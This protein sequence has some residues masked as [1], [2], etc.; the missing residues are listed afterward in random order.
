MYRDIFIA[1]S[2]THGRPAPVVAAMLYAF[3]PVAAYWYVRNVQAEVPFDVTWKAFED[4][5]TGKTLLDFLGEYGLLDLLPAIKEYRTRVEDYR[6]KYIRFSGNTA[7][8]LNQFFVAVRD[9]DKRE[10]GVQKGLD[11]VGGSW[12]SLMAYVRVWTFLMKDWKLQMKLKPREDQ[13]EPVF[14]KFMVSLSA[15]KV[16]SKLSV[17]FPVWGWVWE[18]KRVRR[19]YLGL[20]TD[21]ER[22]DAVRFT[23]VH[24]SS[25]VGGKPWASG[26]PFVYALNNHGKANFIDLS[27]DHEL[28]LSM[29][30]RMYQAAVVGPNFPLAILN[31][32]IG[33]KCASCGFKKVCLGS[34]GTMESSVV[35]RFMD[36]NERERAYLVKHIAENE[37]VEGED[38][39]E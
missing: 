7:A 10:F 26:R 5:A 9:R 29:V 2:E 21:D 11:H 36:E 14:Q 3:C 28:V 23:L 30:S 16:G 37:E 19:E 38:R 8:E 22:Q 24:N 39:N 1:A 27:I 32:D 17:H 18:Y 20:L 12:S 13:A 31:G 35:S 6:D 34:S 15:P 4:Y 25:L 33:E